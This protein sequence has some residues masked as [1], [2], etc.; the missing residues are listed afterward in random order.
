M[1]YNRCAASLVSQCTHIQNFSELDQ[2]AAE[3]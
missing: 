2:L 3:L 1:D